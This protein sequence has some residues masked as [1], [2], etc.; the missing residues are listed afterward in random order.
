MSNKV[1]AILWSRGFSAGIPAITLLFLCLAIGFNNAPSNGSLPRSL[2]NC[3]RLSLSSLDPNWLQRSVNIFCG[4][5]IG[6][7]AICVFYQLIV[8]ALKICADSFIDKNLKYF[9]WIEVI[10]AIVF[11]SL[12]IGIIVGIYLLTWLRS[13][14]LDAFEQRLR[15]VDTKYFSITS[16]M[17]WFAFGFS[18]SSIYNMINVLI[19]VVASKDRCSQEYNRNNIEMK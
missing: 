1:S 13:D 12:F 8:I 9:Y 5:F 11:M 4:L 17:L 15:N 16:T 7:T 18:I 6:L 10:L 2:T 3:T 14:Y 19:S